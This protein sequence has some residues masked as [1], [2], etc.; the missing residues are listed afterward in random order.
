[1]GN[2][3]RKIFGKLFLPGGGLWVLLMSASASGAM[4]Q[5]IHVATPVNGLTAELA[6]RY[7]GV[8]RVHD[9]ASA[10]T[11]DSS[12]NTYVTGWSFGPGTLKDYATIKFDAE[13]NQIW[14][15]R[16]NGYEHSTDIAVAMTVDSSGNVYVTGY[17]WDAG[18][19]TDSATVKYD[20]NGIQQWVARYNGPGT[21]TYFTYDI[22]VDSFGAVSVTG[23]SYGTDT[24]TDYVTV[25]YDSVGNEVLI[26]KQASAGVD[27]RCGRGEP[28][29]HGAP[30][31][32]YINGV[33]VSG[34]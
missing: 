10:A 3:F 29:S 18:T 27:F 17:S 32:V 1:M 22:S 4:P 31:A 16:Y 6:E 12:G 28:G 11:V 34:G 14:V 25:T 7:Y 21:S 8:G 33:N 2:G 9:Q 5:C 19:A 24:D 13:G 20:S 23:Y 15:A 30:P 26:N